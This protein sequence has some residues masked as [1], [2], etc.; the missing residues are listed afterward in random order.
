[1]MIMLSENGELIWGKLTETAFEETEDLAIRRLPLDD[2][3][4]LCLDGTITDAI[5]VAGP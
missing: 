5:S 1:M 3:I 4:K 2:A